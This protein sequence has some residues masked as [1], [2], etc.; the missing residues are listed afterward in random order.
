MLRDKSQR[1][2]LT[3]SNL[4]ATCL[5]NTMGLKLEVKLH[6]VTPAPKSGLHIVVT[7]A[8]H[9]CDYVPKRILKLSQYP[10]Q[11]FH[12]KGHYLES[13]D[14]RCNYMGSKP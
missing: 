10:L 2:H 8:E 13:F 9:V 14:D 1:G 11:I 6:R 4:T 12:V 5:A 3:R 7:I